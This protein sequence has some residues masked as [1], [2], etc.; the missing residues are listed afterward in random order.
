MAE[1]TAAPAAKAPKEKLTGAALAAK[2]SARRKAKTAGRA[3]RKLK[4]KTD[5]EFSKTF[6][7]ARS[8]RANAKK[9][10]FRKK[11]SRKK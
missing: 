11:K 3:K 1:T 7:E 8:T 2:R 4:L 5:K 9:A 6:F 10:A